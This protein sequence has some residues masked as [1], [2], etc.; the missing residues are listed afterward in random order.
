MTGRIIAVASGKGG[1]GKTWLSITLAHAL[2]EAGRRAVLMDADLGLA[3]ADVQ[4]GLNPARDLA[5]VLA[6]AAAED[7]AQPLPAGFHLLAGRSGSGALAGLSGAGLDAA[8]DLPRRLA[9]R[10]QEVVVDLGAG[11]EAPQRRLA[12]LADVLLVVATEEPTSLTDAYAV[13]KLHAKDAPGG[14]ARLV[15]NL[16]GTAAGGQRTHA[17]LEAATRRF[18]A[19]GLD[20]AGVVRR[21]SKVPDAIRHQ[22][23]LLTRHP[24]SIAAQDVR[25][26]ARGLLA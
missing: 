15:V 5:A 22:T 12:A 26:L 6:G 4:L 13:L 10:F 14:V 7:A 17:T 3:N 18:L 21:D 19:R 16:A 1:V 25:A 2:A 20:L 9:T 11:V 24:G 8:L 23:P